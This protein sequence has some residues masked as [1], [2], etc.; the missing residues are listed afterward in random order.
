V[1]Q[2]GTFERLGGTRTLRV[3]VRII[4]AT[5]KARE[6]EVT[7]QRFRADLYYRINV[8]AISLPPLRKRRDAIPLLVAHFLRKY[9]QQNGRDLPTIRPQVLQRI[10]LTFRTLF[11]SA[12]AILEEPPEEKRSYTRPMTYTISPY[13]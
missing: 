3:D 6:Q 4:A 5:N 2:E 9:A 11:R 8:I 12:E 7:A 10:Q 1:L 13:C